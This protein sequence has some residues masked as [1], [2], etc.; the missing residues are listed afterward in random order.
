[1][2][3]REDW[4][5]R[6][7]VTIERHGALPLAWGAS[8]C[9]LFP[10]DCVLAM[11][12]TDIAAEARGAYASLDEG[13]SLLTGRGLADMAEAFASLF[14][15]IAPALAGRGDLGVIVRPH[16]ALPVVFVDTVAV[17][18]SDAGGLRRVPRSL[19][20]RAFRVE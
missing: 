10:A 17:G 18:K 16:G 13:L 15:E 6:L 4:P 14:P 9:L 12:D 3:R 7:L 1:M 2:P 20:T 5:E 19:A 11:T 8:D